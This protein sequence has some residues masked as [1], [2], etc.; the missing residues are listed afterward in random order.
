MTK[1]EKVELIKAL[2]SKAIEVS[3]DQVSLASKNQVEMPKATFTPMT[4]TIVQLQTQLQLKSF[5]SKYKV[6]ELDQMI[7]E[8]T[9]R[10]NELGIRGAMLDNAI[11]EKNKPEEEQPMTEE[12]F[13]QVLIDEPKVEEEVKEEEEVKPKKV[14]NIGQFFK[15][16]DTFEV[17]KKKFKQFAKWLHPDVS[18]YENSQEAFIELQK[19]YEQAEKIIKSGKKVDDV[20]VSVPQDVKDAIS[21]ISDL[22]GVEIKIRGTWVWVAGVSREDKDKHEVLRG[23]GFRYGSKANEWYFASETNGQKKKRGR[24]YNAEQLKDKWGEQT[25]KGQAFKKEKLQ[26]QAQ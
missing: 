26:G 8:L 22:E 6:G 9:N 7:T 3:Q 25:I 18:D 15:G 24:G 23:A 10:I 4:Q 21:K 16:V 14:W 12:E 5:A 20:E 1:Q 11:D 19:Q 17:L 13:E 2:L